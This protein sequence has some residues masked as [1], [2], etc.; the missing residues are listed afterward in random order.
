MKKTVS[1]TSALRQEFNALFASV[2]FNLR[3]NLRVEKVAP[4]RS[5]SSFKAG[6]IEVYKKADPQRDADMPS[7]TKGKPIVTYTFY[8]D[9]YRPGKIGSAAIYGREL[10]SLEMRLRKTGFLFGRK[11]IDMRIEQGCRPFLDVK[12]A[13]V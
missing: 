10:S 9:T 4:S 6:S 5:S 12:L 3:D 8:A 11:I 2:E 7:A 13:V 1:T